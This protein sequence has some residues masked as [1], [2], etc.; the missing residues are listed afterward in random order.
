MPNSKSKK[1]I[2]QAFT[3]ASIIYTGEGIATK[4]GR[5]LEPADLSPIEDGA[6]VFDASKIIW[7]GETKSLPVIYKDIKKTS[8]KNKQAIMPGLIDSHTHLVFAGSRAHEFAR[9]T[10][11]TSY[12]EIANEGGGI[13]TTV[14]ATREASIE[15]LFESYELWCNF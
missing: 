11:G 1:Q 2:I 6:I 3:H 5:R 10:A 14:K 8:L 9:R 4:K 13:L 7:V 15:F 12:Q